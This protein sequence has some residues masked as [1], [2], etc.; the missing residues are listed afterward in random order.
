MALPIR[1]IHQNSN[2]HICTPE[3]ALE[4]LAELAG[5]KV[6]KVLDENSMLIGYT[7]QPEDPELDEFINAE[8]AAQKHEE[9]LVA[10]MGSYLEED[11]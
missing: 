2:R 8:I 11:D 5:F 3:E 10:A 1:Y 9:E 4:S 7:V 6:F